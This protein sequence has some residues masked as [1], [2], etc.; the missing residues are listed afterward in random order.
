MDE[1]IINVLAAFMFFVGMFTLVCLGDVM[2]KIFFED[3]NNK[4]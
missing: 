3:E 1:L 2:H 4:V